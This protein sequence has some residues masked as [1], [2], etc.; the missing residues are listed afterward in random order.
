MNNHSKEVGEV[1]R[2][3]KVSGLE[4]GNEVV[5]RRVTTWLTTASGYLR[6]SSLARTDE[7]LSSEINRLVKKNLYKLLVESLG[8]EPV[9]YGIMHGV[10]P[11]KI[12]QRWL[13]G[14]FGVTNHRVTEKTGPSNILMLLMKDQYFLSNP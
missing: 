3:L 11:T 13:R 10:R 8:F 5:G 2:S 6:K 4:V 12:I 1:E 14:G 7:Q 9:P